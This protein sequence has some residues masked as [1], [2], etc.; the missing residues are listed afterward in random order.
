MRSIIMITI[1]LWYKHRDNWY[2]CTSYTLGIS[3][4]K[5][6]KIARRES[7][8]MSYAFKHKSNGCRFEAALQ[9]WMFT[10]FSN[11]SNILNI[12]SFYALPV[13]ITLLIIDTSLHSTVTHHIIR[14]SQNLPQFFKGLGTQQLLQNIRVLKSIWSTVQQFCHWWC[15]SVFNFCH[16]L[17]QLET[18]N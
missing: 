8:R 12:L 18:A 10:S 7:D 9:S 3:Y 1:S 13:P 17:E 14:V 15:I 6:M 11:F 2:G 16:A 4:A 5:Y